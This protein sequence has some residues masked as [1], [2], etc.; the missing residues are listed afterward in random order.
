MGSVEMD[1]SLR[2]MQA[3]NL[4]IQLGRLEETEYCYE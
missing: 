3:T 2:W 1:C 4:K